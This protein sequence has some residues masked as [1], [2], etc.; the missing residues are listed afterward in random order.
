MHWKDRD[1]AW[2]DLQSPCDKI[3]EELFSAS[4]VVNVGNGRTTSF[5]K[6]SWIHGQ[7]PKNI[8]PSLFKKAKKKNILFFHALR[9]NR[10]IQLCLP[11]I[12]EDEIK[13]FVTLWQAISNMHDLNNL[14]DTI[15]WRWTTDG[16]YS[17]SSAYNIQFSTNFCTMKICSIWKAK[18]ELKCRFFVWTL[19]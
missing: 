12:R 15:S 10:W 14:E 9:T 16:Q 4:T 19:T 6:S 3:D 7:A 17:A 18:T 13:D 5:W 1:K 8:E 11:C 2:I